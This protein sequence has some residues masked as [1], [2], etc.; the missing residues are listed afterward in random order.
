M[1]GSQEL[2][3]TSP[4][5]IRRQEDGHEH[6]LLLQEPGR[7]AVPRLRP[8]G[9][10]QQHEASGAA[11]VG[12]VNIDKLV[13][14]LSPRPRDQCLPFTIENRGVKGNV[15]V[16]ARDIRPFET[17]IIDRPAIIGPF[18]DTLPECL[19]C[20]KEVSVDGYKVGLSMS[21]QSVD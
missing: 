16:A 9:D 3:L 11:Q 13:L 21:I 8:G 12:T 2:S 18:D 4:G 10:M 1:T 14:T 20:Y 15:I 7:G 5:Q 19:E 6:L 17:I